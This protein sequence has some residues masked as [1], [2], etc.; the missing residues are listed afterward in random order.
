MGYSHAAVET[1]SRHVTFRLRGSLFKTYAMISEG[2]R[3]AKI[4]SALRGTPA[5]IRPDR[6]SGAAL[7]PSRFGVSMGDSRIAR[8]GSGRGVV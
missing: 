8:E 6:T 5:S 2:D 7:A 3:C 1:R 4:K